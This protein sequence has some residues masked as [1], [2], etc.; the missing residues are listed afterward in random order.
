MNASPARPGAIE[1]D[2]DPTD[3]T[4]IVGPCGLAPDLLERWR[5]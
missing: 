5:R 1:I 4:L 3:A 2:Y